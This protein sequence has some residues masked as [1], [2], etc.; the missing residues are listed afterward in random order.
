MYW[1]TI[2]HTAL[3][4]G[5]RGLRGMSDYRVVSVHFHKLSNRNGNDE[6]PLLVR[7]LTTTSPVLIRSWQGWRSC[8]VISAPS[9]W[10]CNSDRMNAT[11]QWKVFNLTTTLKWKFWC[12]LLYFGELSRILCDVN[13]K[14]S[15]AHG[16]RRVVDDHWFSLYAPFI[17]SLGRDF[18]T[19]C[20]GAIRRHIIQFFHD[21]CVQPRAYHSLKNIF[22][23]I[24][25]LGRCKNHVCN[26]QCR[27]TKVEVIHPVLVSSAGGW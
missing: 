6:V 27:N 14:Y 15:F 24:C 13:R 4:P 25:S 7:S 18:R 12:R 26:W 17:L 16:Y 23:P 10:V 19:K 5:M 1:S 9:E 20:T 11:R 3:S 21:R 22:E 8:Q 2:S